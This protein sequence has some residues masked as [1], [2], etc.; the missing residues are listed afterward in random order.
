MS[1]AHEIANKMKDKHDRIEQK[2]DERKAA[3]VAKPTKKEMVAP[4]AP[5]QPV[6]PEGQA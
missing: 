1:T 5:P 3:A 4:L 2:R 6:T